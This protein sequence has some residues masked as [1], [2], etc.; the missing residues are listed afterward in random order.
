MVDRKRPWQLRQ[1]LNQ[2]TVVGIKGGREGV[3]TQV[4][5]VVE[6]VV[7]V[8]EEDQQQVHLSHR[9]VA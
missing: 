1:L 7:V 3:V 5:V 2:G 4:E 9:Q 6:V 8:V